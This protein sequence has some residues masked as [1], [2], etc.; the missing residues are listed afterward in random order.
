VA[1]DYNIP[2]F[3]KYVK[4]DIIASSNRSTGQT[5]YTLSFIYNISELTANGTYAF[6]GTLVA[7]S[8]Y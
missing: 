8:T 4:G 6:N 2:N 3:F 7:T 1:A 5:D